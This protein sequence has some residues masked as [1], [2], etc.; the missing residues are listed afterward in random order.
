MPSKVLMDVDEYLHASF[1]GPDCE[2]LDGEVVERNISELPHGIL[3][4]RLIFLLMQA[5]ERLRIRVVPEIR[6]QIHPG[7]FAWQTWLPGAPAILEIGFP[8]LPPSW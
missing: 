8:R 7:A 3:Q 5:A 6:I 2:Y 1:D 4:G